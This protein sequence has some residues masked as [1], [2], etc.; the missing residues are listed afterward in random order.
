MWN[1]RTVDFFQTSTES[2][3]GLACTEQRIDE[4]SEGV[5]ES[6]EFCAVWQSST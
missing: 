5:D 1:E 2:A 6:N 3:P 4:G